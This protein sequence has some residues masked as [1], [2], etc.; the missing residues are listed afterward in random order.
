LE[1]LAIVAW[2]SPVTGAVNVSAKFRER[3]FE[4][5]PV[6][7]IGWSVEKGTQTVKSGRIGPA[8]YDDGALATISRLPVAK[9]DVLYFVVDDFLHASDYIS[10]SID[11][12]VTITQ[13][14]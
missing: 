6:I 4:V 9:N 5:M 1:R 2:Q 7:S 12:Q 8:G 11:L 10:D 14:Q 3:R 13:V